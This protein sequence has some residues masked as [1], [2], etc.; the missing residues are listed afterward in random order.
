M[1]LIEE[2]S[3][4]RVV[5]HLHNLDCTGMFLSPANQYED[6]K[7][8]DSHLWV[9]VFEHTRHMLIVIER[10]QFFLCHFELL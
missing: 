8:F 7:L 1:M 10:D 5:R 9:D 3:A 4:P 6:L 2:D